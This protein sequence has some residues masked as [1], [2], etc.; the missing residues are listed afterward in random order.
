MARR[1]AAL[2]LWIGRAAVLVAVVAGLLL[3]LWGARL[4]CE[5]NP[6]CPWPVLWRSR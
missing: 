5:L 6:G 4:A 3:V 2:R 1:R